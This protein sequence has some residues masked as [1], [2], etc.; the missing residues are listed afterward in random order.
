[1][2]SEGR[3]SRSVRLQGARPTRRRSCW[4]AGRRTRRASSRA[5]PSST[6]SPRRASLSCWSRCAAVRYLGCQCDAERWLSV[7]ETCRTDAR[8]PKSRTHA[9]RECNIMSLTEDLRAVCDACPRV[10]PVIISSDL[11]FLLENQQLCRSPALDMHGGFPGTR[12]DSVHPYRG[13]RS[14]TLLAFRVWRA[15]PKPLAHAS[16]A[17]V[18][19]RT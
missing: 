11:P 16:R 5:S 14:P 18:C 8:H 17:L 7:A 3:H 2:T 4:R 9:M 12:K 10:P 13:S 15:E 6:R 1:M 19:R